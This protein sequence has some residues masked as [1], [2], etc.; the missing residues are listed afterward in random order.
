MVNTHETVAS[1]GLDNPH[2]GSEGLT[3]RPRLLQPLRRSRHHQLWRP[4]GF[5]SRLRQMS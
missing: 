1:T 5:G 2:D 4:P 3:P